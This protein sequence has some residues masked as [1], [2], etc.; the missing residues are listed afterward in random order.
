MADDSDIVAALRAGDEEVF[1]TVVT[2]LTPGL[3]RLARH[4]V[5]EALA[6]EVAQETWVA[7]ICSIDRF[8]ERSSLKTW[9]YRIMLNKV[10]TLGP[11]EAKVVPFAAL[12]HISDGTVHSVDPER[13]MREG[14]PGHWTQPPSTVAASA[15]RASR[16]PRGPSRRSP[17]R[18]LG[19][20]RHNKKSWKLRDIR[21]WTAEDVCHTLDISSVNQRVL[22]HRGRTAL[23]NMLEEYLHDL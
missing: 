19:C 6:E 13:L 18:S 4:Y 2:E 9:I 5:S 3:I 12:G 15:R 10:R 16:G 23:R 11:R 22:L 8:A 20:R 1:R 21:G 17:R 7:V 14:S